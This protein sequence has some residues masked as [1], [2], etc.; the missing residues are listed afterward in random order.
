MAIA[1][2]IVLG[3]SGP[4]FETGRRRDGA[5]RARRRIFLGLLATKAPSRW[6]AIVVLLWHHSH[7][8]GVIVSYLFTSAVSLSLRVRYVSLAL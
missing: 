3:I 5:F 6:L 7:R 1:Q 8:F 4:Q 2:K